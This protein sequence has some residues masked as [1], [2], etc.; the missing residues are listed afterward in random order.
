MSMVDAGT[1]ARLGVPLEL[2]GPIAFVL[3]SELA[4]VL[5]DQGSHQ[6]GRVRAYVM[7]SCHK[8]SGCT[9]YVFVDTFASSSSSTS[10]EVAV[11]WLCAWESMGALCGDRKEHV[12]VAPDSEQCAE[13]LRHLHRR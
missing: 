11:A 2:H 5:F 10:A 3:P 12:R 1:R 9:K 4:R 6:S 8:G 7:C 13:A